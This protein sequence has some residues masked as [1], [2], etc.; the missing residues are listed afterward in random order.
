MSKCRDLGLMPK[1]TREKRGGVRKRKTERVK[2]EQVK[3]E[4][5]TVSDNSASQLPTTPNSSENVSACEDKTKK[6][7]TICIGLLNAQSAVPKAFDI[8]EMILEKET[9]LLCLTETWL[10]ERGDEV[11]I[12]KMTPPGHTCDRSKEGGKRRTQTLR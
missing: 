8:H 7:A 10:R 2:L 6:K 5:E 1:I 3:L 9:D 4:T 12:G 11:A